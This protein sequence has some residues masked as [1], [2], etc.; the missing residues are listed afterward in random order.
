[1]M[2]ADNNIIIARRAGNNVVILQVV[3]RG[4]PYPQE[5]ASTV[6]HVMDRLGHSHPYFLVWQSKVC[7]NCVSVAL[8]INHWRDSVLT[9]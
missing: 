3:E 6:Q 7:I 8:L 2:L 5:V 1:M 4:D 9:W